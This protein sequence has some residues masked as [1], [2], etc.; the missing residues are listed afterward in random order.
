M[1]ILY[2]FNSIKENIDLA[3]SLGLDFVELN[4]N[5]GYCRDELESNKEII[6]LMKNTDLEYT[7]HFYDEADFAS[8]DEVV[9]G[10][11][12]LLNKYLSYAKDIN[13]KLLNVHLNVGPIVTI[14]GVKNYI[15]EKE[16][17]KFI[18][19]LINNLKEVEK[20]CNGYNIK[21]VI[22]NVKIPNFLKQAYKD[23]NKAN[24]SF[25]YDI[26]HDHTSGDVLKD[27]LLNESFRFEEFHIHDSLGN[28]D[29][30]EIGQGELDINFYKNL[31][32][33]SYIVLEV[34]SKEDLI[35]SV[36]KFKEM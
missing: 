25:N 5:F 1:P 16:Y 3:K 13:I 2:E 30:L 15:Y 34:K 21:L 23:L 35:K 17:T 9:E 7:L 29:H 6:D 14:S 8:Y 27:M 12:K 24:F 19:K 32:K 31:A 18:N 33:E 28:K 26:G 36:N 22:E 4:L 10:Y 11:I 20:I